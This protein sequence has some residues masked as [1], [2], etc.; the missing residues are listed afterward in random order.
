MFRSQHFFINTL[1]FLH[2]LFQSKLFKLKPMYFSTIAIRPVNISVFTLVLRAS[3]SHNF[4]L[5]A[6]FKCFLRSCDC[7]YV[8]NLSI[9]VLLKL[10][11]VWWVV[12]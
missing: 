4:L 3:K 10:D 8:Y 5:I 1:T 9:L 6:H 12:S 2:I 11:I 7:S